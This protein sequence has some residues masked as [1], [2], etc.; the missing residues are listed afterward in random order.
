MQS[1]RLCIICK[2]S[3]AL[4]GH[5]NCPLLAKIE[6][7]PKNKIGEEFFGP[8]PSIFVGRIGYP[9]VFAGPLGALATD[10]LQSVDNPSS[11][12]GR[13]YEDIIALRSLLLRGK[14]KQSVF[15]RGK[16]IE[17]MQELAMAEKPTDIEMSFSGKPIYKFSFSDVMQPMGPS[18]TLNKLTIAENPKISTS[19]EKIVNDELKAAEASY[20]LYKQGS[21]V[22]KIST[23]I[24]SGALGYHK[25]RRLVP[26]RYSIT[27][28]DDIICKQMLEEVRKFSQLNS[29]FVYSSQFLDNHFEILLMP[30][31][32][33]YE[34]F[35]AWAPGSFWSKHLKKAEIVEEY[36]P[37]S[38]RTA[39]A[40]QEGGGYY[41]ARL[42][43]VEALHKMKKQARIIVFREI[44]EGYTIPLGVWQV[45]E[46]VRNA[47]KQKPMSFATLKE[48]LNHINSN[49]RLPVSEYAKQSRILGQKRILD[50][51]IHPSSLS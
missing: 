12:F 51:S 22:Y 18:V 32:W 37:Y 34:N 2:G 50:F 20:A 10:E 7:K 14:Q 31:S 13:S 44:Y 24:S 33:E 29:F 47:M 23:I 8:S 39:Y 40:D 36:E 30:G 43:V 17:E 28:I 5:A 48:A 49:L 3:R 4:C 27:A 35:E 9:N 11:W 42:A 16:Y 15:S 6:A 26:T 1:A 41:A 46:N 38:G 19:V 25:N 21:D 45:R